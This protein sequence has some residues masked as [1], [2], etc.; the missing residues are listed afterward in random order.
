MYAPLSNL[1][2]NYRKRKKELTRFLRGLPRRKVRGL[3]AKAIALHKEAFEKIDCLK[4]GNCCKTMNPTWKKAEIKRIAKHVGMTYK[5]YFAKYLV[6]EEGDIMNKNTPCQHLA[7]DNKCKVYDIRP[8][9]CSGFPHTHNRGFE[10]Y[11]SGTHIQNIEYCPAT[12]YVVEK[13]FE[14]IITDKKG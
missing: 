3:D 8:G 13:L 4:C 9:D 2:K 5:E 1:K 10:L 14:K 11:I 7:K 6:V 12:F